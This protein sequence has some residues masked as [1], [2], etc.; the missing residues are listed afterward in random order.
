MLVLRT[1]RNSL[2][3]FWSIRAEVG[4]FEQADQMG[5]GMASMVAGL[6]WHGL[7]MISCLDTNIHVQGIVLSRIN[8]GCHAIKQ[9]V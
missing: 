5:C 9:D 7:L 1:E 6:A 8:L 3:K 2:E 4:V